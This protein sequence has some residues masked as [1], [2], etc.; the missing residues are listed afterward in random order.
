MKLGG[1]TA[2]NEIAD[3]YAQVLAATG[4]TGP[5][6]FVQAGAQG[7]PA[8]AGTEEFPLGVGSMRVS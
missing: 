4:V 5:F 1:D 7:N 3:D 6:P 2:G 8:L